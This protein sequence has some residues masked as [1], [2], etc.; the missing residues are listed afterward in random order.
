[1]KVESIAE[2]SL[3]YGMIGLGK[4]SRFL[5]GPLR[6]ILLYTIKFN[7]YPI[8]E[9]IKINFPT[10]QPIPVKQGRERGNKNIFKVSLVTNLFLSSTKNQFLYRY[11]SVHLG[12]S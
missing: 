2:C 4:K 10:D 7:G 12:C 6:Q 3:H 11:H 8:W 1:M 9:I 5:S